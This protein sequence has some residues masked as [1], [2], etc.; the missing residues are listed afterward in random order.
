MY[1]WPAPATS[2][3]KTGR[4]AATANGPALGDVVVALV[5]ALRVL[6]LLGYRAMSV[7]LTSTSGGALPVSWTSIDLSTLTLT[8]RTRPCHDPG[9]H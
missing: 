8:A 4:R 7:N 3:S 9:E 2:R 5:P 1:F 6:F